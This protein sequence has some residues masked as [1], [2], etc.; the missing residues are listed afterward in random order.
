VNNDSHRSAITVCYF[1]IGDPTYSRNRIF[2]K[3][4][5]ANGVTVIECMSRLSGLQKYLDL[6]KKHWKL[7]H[8]Y[9]AIMVGYPGQQSVLLA[10]ILTGKPIIFD[11]LVSL[12]DSLVCDRAVISPRSIRAYYFWLID[13]LSFHLADHIIVDTNEHGTYFAKTF[14][15]HSKKITRIFIGSDDE[16]VFPLPRTHHDDTFTV[17]FHGGFNPLQGVDVIVRAAK[18]LERDQ[19]SFTIIGDGQTFKE[20]HALAEKIGVSNV[21][22]INRVPYEELRVRLAT[23][24]MSLGIFGSTEKAKRVIPNKVYEA[25]ATGTPIVTADTPAIAEL[26]TDREQVLLSAIGD[27]NNLA[28][29]IRELKMDEGLRTRIARRGYE[30]FTARLTPAVLGRELLSVIMSLIHDASRYR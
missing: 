10:R 12:Y 14:K 27:E 8:H 28:E 23:A 5:R 20:V 13:W 7:R 18:I 30:L 16:V 2:I 21:S 17:H 25:L 9:D 15:I 11:A 19:I 22:F 26:L 29:K 6:I 24:D 4:L 3:G 1:G